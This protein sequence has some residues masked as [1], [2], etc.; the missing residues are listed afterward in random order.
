[1]KNP[2]IKFEVWKVNPRSSGYYT[3]STVERGMY[4]VVDAPEREVFGF[5]V[6]PEPFE[7]DVSVVVGVLPLPFVDGDG[8]GRE[9]S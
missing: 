4:F 3:V 9:S 6:F 7:G 1:V 2:V 8:G 5:V